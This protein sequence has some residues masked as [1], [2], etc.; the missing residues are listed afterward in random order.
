MTTISTRTTPCVAPTGTERLLLSLGRRLELLAIERMRRR[1][2]S[3]NRALLG[4]RRAADERRRDA[5]A[6]GMFGV[7]PR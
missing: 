6:Y 5:Q 1:A 3:A 7:L 2:T 4:A